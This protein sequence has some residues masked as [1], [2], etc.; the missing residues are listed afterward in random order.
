[1]SRYPKVI[2]LGL[3]LLTAFWM[4]GCYTAFRHPPINEHSWSEIVVTDDCLE[5]HEE[6]RYSTPVLPESAE[7]DFNWQFYSGS[8]WWQDEGAIV[9]D[10]APEPS[11]TGPRDFGNSYTPQ[12]VQPV[13][14]PVQSAGSLGKSTVSDEN[15]ENKQ[16]VSSPTRSA[17]RRSHT[18]SSSSSQEDNSEKRSRKR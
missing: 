4:H 16:S 14:M 3:F 6:N 18:T 17:G 2:V 8:A 10:D 5:C 1:M 13:A 7:N 15:D 11:G 12:S 9:A